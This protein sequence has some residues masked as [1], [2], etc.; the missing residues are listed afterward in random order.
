MRAQVGDQLVVESN[1]S[2]RARRDGEIVG[3]HHRDGTP[4]YDVRWSGTDEVCVV[5][6]GPDAHVHHVPHGR[7]VGREREGYGMPGGSHQV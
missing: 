7:P 3:L 1:R 2:D 5:V 6:P 4:P